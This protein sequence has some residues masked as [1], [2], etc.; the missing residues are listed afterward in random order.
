LEHFLVTVLGQTNGVVAYGLVFVALLLCGLGL[1]LP[2]DVILITAGYL[3]YSKAVTFNVMVLVGFVGILA[4]DSCIFFFGRRLGRN[5]KPTSWVGKMVTLEKLQKVEQLFA[6]WGQKIV[7]AARFMPGVRAGVYFA[8]GASGMSYAR[9][10]L[11]DGVAACLSAPLFVYGG[12]RFGGDIT[13]FIK[14]A[15]K[16]ELRVLGAGLFILIVYLL[17]QRQR[18]K[19]AAR[20]VAALLASREPAPDVAEVV[21]GATPEREVVGTKH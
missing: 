11:F 12:K 18:Q 4:G 7:M 9:F 20:R 13:H 1:P 15:Q 8:A 16:S 2:E 17:W 10:I 6:R 5:V 21:P 3:A 14:V 19:L